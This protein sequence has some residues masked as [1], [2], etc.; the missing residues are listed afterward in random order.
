[1]R[2][3]RIIFDLAKRALKARFAKV[4]KPMD[5]KE[6]IASR[7]DMFARLIAV[8][9]L[10]SEK[11]SYKEIQRI[12]DDH[13]EQLMLKK[14]AVPMHRADDRTIEDLKYIDHEIEIYTRIRSIPDTFVA[15]GDAFMDTKKEEL[16]TVEQPVSAEKV[17]ECWK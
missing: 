8:K 4:E 2:V 16:I 6:I 1:M 15:L 7:E 14:L 5:K 10:V 17:H 12:L 9:K 3:P 11:S 13:V